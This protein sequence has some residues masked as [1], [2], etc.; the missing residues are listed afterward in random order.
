MEGISSWSL[1]SR[2][3]VSAPAGLCIPADEAAAAVPMYRFS[4]LQHSVFQRGWST[5]VHTSAAG[6]ADCCL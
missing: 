3:D 4:Q 1:Q 5:R 2:Q 6:H